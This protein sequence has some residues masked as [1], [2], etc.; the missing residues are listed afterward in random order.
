MAGS[1][2]CKMNARAAVGLSGGIPSQNEVFI[3]FANGNINER[4]QK[5]RNGEKLFKSTVV[6]IILLF[7]C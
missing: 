3:A 1:T 2:K 6:Y 5:K 4:A 7:M